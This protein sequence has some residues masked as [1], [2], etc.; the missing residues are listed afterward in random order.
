MLLHA[1][2]LLQAAEAIEGAM[3]ALRCGPCTVITVAVSTVP[4][5]SLLPRPLAA[6]RCGPVRRRRYICGW[7]APRVLQWVKDGQA[8]GYRLSCGS[9]VLPPGPPLW[10]RT[11][12]RASIHPPSGRVRAGQP[13]GDEGGG[14]GRHGAP[15]SP[16]P[17]GAWSKSVDGSLGEPWRDCFAVPS[18]HSHVSVLLE[19]RLY[20]GITNDLIQMSV[21]LEEPGDLNERRL[22]DLWFPTNPEKKA[23]SLERE[24][25]FLC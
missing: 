20:R 17:P 10:R 23:R 2:R 3:A 11:A 7:Q 16:K 8:P 25:A 19:K 12:V 9:L 22:T 5:E 21:G 13:G 18:R 1:E 14:P 4:G 15:L 6:L 24:R